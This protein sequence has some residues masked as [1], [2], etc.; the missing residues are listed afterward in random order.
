MNKII[1]TTPKKKDILLKQGYPS[2]V[3]KIITINELYQN[4]PYEYDN[5]TL[6]FIISNYHIILPI[7]KNYL[8]QITTF[9]VEQI[10]NTKGKFLTELKQELIQKG[11]LK[12]NIL[13]HN[14]LAN[15]QLEVDAPKT[16]KLTKLL[17][18]FPNVTY[19]E[20]EQR[21]H[22]NPTIY[23]FNTMEQEIAYILEKIAS[24][25]HQGIS[26]DHIYL[27]N[28][29]ENYLF[30]LKETA[31]LYNIPLNLKNRITLNMTYLGSQFL[32]GL[33][34][35][36]LTQAIE[37]LTSL[38]HTEEEI[39]LRNQIIQM[40]NKYIDLE[41]RE[42]FITGDL[43]TSK[44][45]KPIQ[46]NTLN[47]ID[48]IEHSFTEEDY[49][50]ILNAD[51][52][53]FPSPHKDEDF[54]N[55]K[56]KEMQNIDTSTD[57]NILTKKEYL[58]Q[59]EN[60]PNA[61]ISYAIN[62]QG[63]TRYPS[64]LLEQWST[65]IIKNPSLSFNVSN[66]FNKLYL[67]KEL[68]EFT[69][70]NTVSKE[71]NLLN[72]NYT[73]FYR[74]YDHSFTN[75][76]NTIYLK[77]LKEHLNLSYTSL[78]TY[79]KCP[80]RYYLT[81]ILKIAPFTETFSIFIGNLFHKILEIAFQNQDWSTIYDQEISQHDFS[82]KE[83]F[84]LKKLKQELA[85]TIETINKQNELSDLKETLTEQKVVIN[86]PKINNTDITFEG[87]ID[88]I[89]YTDNVLTITDYK[90]NNLKYQLSYIPLGFHTQ[91]PIYIYLAKHLPMLTNTTLGGIYIQ[92]IIPSRIRYNPNTTYEKAKQNEL[93]LSGYTLREE[94]I[95]KQID[96]SY[97]D[98]QKIQGLK[99]KNDGNFYS[100][101]KTLT[102]ED[103]DILSQ[104]MEDLIQ[105]VAN[106]IINGNFSMTS[107][108][109]D[110]KDNISCAYC[111]FN[112]ICY[113]TAK[114][115]VYLQSDKNYLKEG[116]YHGLDE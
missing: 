19:H 78:D 9:E 24:L 77:S 47:E 97:K 95:I 96:H 7:A 93:K 54:F 72:S 81:Y 61:F 43:S 8:T 10:T 67:A 37:K 21:N 73:I 110:N 30:T 79:Q 55:D 100:S 5:H 26:I 111:P 66:A 35:T 69:K 39:K 57:L 17:K 2:N 23:Q 68:D 101:A 99:I 22:Y 87:K 104:T 18:S 113:H 42:M 29:P 6:D 106:N 53:S 109:I 3:S 74:K 114:D 80:F 86:L 12:K 38:C 94:N 89:N 115:T 34:Q 48:W 40:I 84:F 102:K 112:D 75:I 45:N 50:F 116:D 36:N 65:N 98:S 103:F 70:Y 92:N 85:F 52:L 56:I 71:L 33:N 44:R 88:K 28:I 49:L 41:N 76:S 46:K 1:I 11:L 64:S 82:Y 20:Q 25:I 59:L 83:L 108:I 60:I 32:K 31:Y 105:N 90:T 4:Y 63:S 91:L 58:I 16:K 15:H 14:F 51:T 107:K 62:V 27:S 13:F